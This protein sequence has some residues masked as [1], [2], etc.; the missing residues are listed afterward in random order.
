MT[1]DAELGEFAEGTVYACE[2]IRIAENVGQPYSLV[3]A[4]T[5]MARLSIIRG[6]VDGAA[7]L[8]E[9]ALELCETANL[10]FLFPH[11]AAVMGATYIGRG[12]IAKTLLQRP[13]AARGSGV[14]KA[15]LRP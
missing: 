15:G 8:A 4:C 14:E 3:V 9:R 13:A 6:D 10:P 1:Y 5:E 11:A 7:P 12:R 2:A